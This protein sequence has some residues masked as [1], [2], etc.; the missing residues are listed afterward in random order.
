MNISRRNFLG[1]VVA[2]TAA[3][4]IVRAGILM[5]VKA[6]RPWPW[7][8]LYGGVGGIDRAPNF[9][10]RNRRLEFDESTT[11]FQQIDLPWSVTYEEMGRIAR[12]AGDFYLSGVG[13]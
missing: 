6:L 1:F 5:P 12:A 13:K 10:W 4:A 9:W 7:R 11:D 8:E 2:A 3:P